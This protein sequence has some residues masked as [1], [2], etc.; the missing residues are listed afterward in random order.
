MGAGV[1]SR[2]SERSV[3]V[4]R[5]YVRGAMHLLLFINGNKIVIKVRNGQAGRPTRVR[6]IVNCTYMYVSV[7]G[8]I[9]IFNGVL[10]SVCTPHDGLKAVT[11]DSVPTRAAAAV[12]GR[13]TTVTTAW[14]G[15]G[16]QCNA[17]HSMQ[18]IQSERTQ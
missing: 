6:A 17:V 5:R 10:Y 2:G 18:C 16:S 7:T 12:H 15:N 9:P 13:H 14:K 4:V 8:E 3:Y 11:H 1:R